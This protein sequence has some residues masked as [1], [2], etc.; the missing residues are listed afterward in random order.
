MA[1]LTI[2]KNLKF[3]PL[4]PLPASA[5]TIIE[6]VDVEMVAKTLIFDTINLGFESKEPLTPSPKSQSLVAKKKKC[7][8]EGT[9]HFQD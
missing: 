1:P 6:S 3:K 8:H 4:F 2:P 7:D 5:I 9:H